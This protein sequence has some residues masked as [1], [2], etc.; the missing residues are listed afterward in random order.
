MD[1]NNIILKV[2]N[3][4]ASTEEYEILQ[5]WKKESQDNIT[6]MEENRKI[7][8]ET[9]SLG[10]YKDYDANS[11]WNRVERK[12][13]HETPN[14]K[15]LSYSIAA[16]LIIGLGIA[17]WSFMGNNA[18]AIPTEY[19]TQGQQNDFAL[20][21]DS[22]I[23]LNQNSSLNVISDF[24]DQRK[25]SMTGEAYFDIHR[26]EARSFIVEFSDDKYLEVLGTEFNIIN[27]DKFEIYVTEGKVAFHDGDKTIQLL[28]GDALRE[29]DGSIVKYR[30]LKK[31]YLA[32][33]NKVLVFEDEPISSVLNTLGRAFNKDVVVD[34][35]IQNSNCKLRNRFEDQSMDVILEELT[36]I[37]D[38]KYKV[39]DDQLHF[40]YIKC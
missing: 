17:L 36:K 30:Q 39:V 13:P 2:L 40:Y 19:I 22:K 28:A 9:E 18:T 23:W 31:N 38:L 6:I 37:F 8:K 1:I 34:K 35:A 4:E 12:L 29:V 16:T 21:D 32:W 7:W 5:S 33:K 27:N 15:W 20:Q 10:D 14:N 11:A 26:D 3:D 25:V 24:K